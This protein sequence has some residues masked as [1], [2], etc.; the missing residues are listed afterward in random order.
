M[1]SRKVN[2][3][4]RVS[5]FKTSGF[6][7]VRICLIGKKENVEGNHGRQFLD[8]HLRTEFLYRSSLKALSQDRCRH[9]A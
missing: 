4:S 8:S 7:T 5:A 3:V 1:R 6:A 2:E 9:A